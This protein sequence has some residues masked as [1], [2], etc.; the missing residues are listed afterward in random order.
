[1]TKNVRSFIY[2]YKLMDTFLK[3]FDGHNGL[4]CRL[5]S[6]ALLSS[7]KCVSTSFS[8]V[9]SKFTFRFALMFRRSV[10][11][12]LDSTYS[13]YTNLLSISLTHQVQFTLVFNYQLKIVSKTIADCFRTWVEGR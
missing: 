2:M 5:L 10:C 9:L 1:M 8:S 12:H 6:I 11:S 7:T 13:R 4:S 3:T